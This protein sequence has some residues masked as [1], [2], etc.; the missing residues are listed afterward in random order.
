[1]GVSFGLL[2][3]R[4]R[5]ALLVELLVAVVVVVVPAEG[6]EL[7][8]LEEV[9]PASSWSSGTLWRRLESGRRGIEDDR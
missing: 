3:R 9:D 1:M 2:L 6:R 8:R 7:D 4:N 5:D